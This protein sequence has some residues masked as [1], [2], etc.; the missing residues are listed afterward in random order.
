MNDLVNAL[1]QHMT[2][3]EVEFVYNVEVLGLPARKAATMAGMPVTKIMAPHLIQARESVK[4]ELRGRLAIT[5]EDVVH[6]YQD[7]IEQAKILGEPAVAIMGWE[8]I[9]KILGY[10]TPQKIDVHI[11]ASVE[12]MAG[13]VKAMDD[14]SLMK[15]LGADTIIDAD[16][17]EVGTG[18][19]G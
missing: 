5:K 17:Y 2:Q 3:D 7:A 16:F 13:Q 18:K 14:A 1:P 8:K 15:L 10:D 12:A 11:T 4:R 9:A 6:G 19:P